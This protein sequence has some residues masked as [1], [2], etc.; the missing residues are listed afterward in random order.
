MYAPNHACGERGSWRKSPPPMNDWTVWAAERL[1]SVAS[2]QVVGQRTCSFFLIQYFNQRCPCSS[3][4]HD[5]EMEV[6]TAAQSKIKL[7]VC[8]P[9]R[10][11]LLLAALKKDLIII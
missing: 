4:Q 1:I 9:L 6:S 2:S 5:G 8:K 10:S 7:R 3:R 11:F